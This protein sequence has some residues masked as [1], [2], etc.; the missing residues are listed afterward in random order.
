MLT[1]LLKRFQGYS[2]EK[3][4]AAAINDT[5]PHVVVEYGRGTYISGINYLN[6]YARNDLKVTVG[7]FSSIAG[8]LSIFLAGNHPTDFV[9]TYPFGFTG[10]T[11]DWSAH[12]DYPEYN[13]SKGNIQIGSD[14]WIGASATIMSGITIG[15]GA[16]IGAQS[17]VA[18]D[19]PPYAIFCGN[20]ARLIG[21]RFEDSVIKELLK[22][23]WWD[24]EDEKIEEAIAYMASS[25]VER[26]LRKY[27]S[28]TE[29]VGVVK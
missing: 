13:R 23:A 26:F 5:V 25:D 16:V 27:G 6:T 9:S 20:P 4:L 28:S 11:R 2:Q 7:S 3:P 15:H 18:R 8:N 1:A 29:S 24:W 10:Y 22:L 17:V 21:Y 14:V 19:V 12:V